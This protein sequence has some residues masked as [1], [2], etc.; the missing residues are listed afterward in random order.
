M[1][2]PNNSLWKSQKISP[3]HFIPFFF[4]LLNTWLQMVPQLQDKWIKDKTCPVISRKT[5]NISWSHGWETQSSLQGNAIYIWIFSNT[6][7]CLRSPVPPGNISTVT[8]KDRLPP[9]EGQGRNGN[10]SSKRHVEEAQTDQL[11]HHWDLSQHHSLSDS[12]K[13][14]QTHTP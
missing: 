9:W 13:H 7:P 8:P 1:A 3:R 11:K 2:F 6:I 4:F 10:V 14:P 5:H 12:K